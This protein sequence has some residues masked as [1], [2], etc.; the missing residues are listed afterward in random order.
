[1][2]PDFNFEDIIFKSSL[3]SKWKNIWP[4]NIDKGTKYYYL[5]DDVKN[6]NERINYYC[7]ECG[8]K[9]IFAPDKIA[10]FNRIEVTNDNI[11]KLLPH[12]NLFYKTY[13]CSANHEHQIHFGFLV[14]KNEIIKI[15]EYPSKYDTVVDSFNNYKKI[16]SNEQ[17]TELAKASQLET[18]GYAI[19]AFL[20][21]RRIFENIIFETFK[22]A[23]IETKISEEEFRNKRMDEKKEYIKDFLP[24]Y[25]INNSII[26]GILSK[27]I[28]E[29]IEKECQ[30]FLPVVK[31]VIF[32][33]LDEAVDK[34][35][36]ELRKQ[37]FTNKLKDIN[38]K[39][40]SK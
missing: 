6:Y 5:A 39:L 15:A 13:R 25:L 18:F 38:T 28:H 27:G 26:Y 20:Y 22:N 21:Y 19:A 35:N 9:R 3:Y 7:T 10:T 32:Y 11:N 29:L 40:H 14:Y 34:K 4:I 30:E 12:S 17:L 24:D 31:A 2:K 37:E 16:L 8:I 33:S 1:M 36:K 23:E